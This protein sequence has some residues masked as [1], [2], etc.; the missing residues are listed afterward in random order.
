M[1]SW[2]TLKNTK[3]FQRVYQERKSFANRYLIMYR[4][5][6][7]LD[8]TRIGISVS[9]KVGNSVIRHRVTRLIRET[10]RLNQEWI[11]SGYDIVIVARETVKEQSFYEVDSAFMHLIRMHNL[12]IA[13]K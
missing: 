7:N 8:V 11:Q 2:I 12:K 9:K 4:A 6:N 3:E 5:K 13:N 10:F 1:K